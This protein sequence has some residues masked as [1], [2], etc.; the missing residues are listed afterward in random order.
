[1]K[2]KRLGT[3][4]LT[5]II[6][7]T[8]LAGCGAMP[9]TGNGNET[10]ENASVIAATEEDTDGQITLRVVDWSDGS[11]TQRE[12]FHK[13]FEEA[14]PDIKIE[15]TML[16]V[17]QF[18]NTIVT[19]IKSGEGP[20]LFPIP[21][22]LTLNTAVEEGWFQPINDYVTDEFR[23]K[24][25]PEAFAE[26]VTDIGDEWYTVTEQMPIIQCLFFY[27]KDILNQQVLRRFPQHI[28]SLEKPVKKLQRWGM[29]MFMV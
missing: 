7:A 27:N 18:K 1:M 28:Q 13:K 23:N 2:L 11:A 14:H 6:A 21:V 8:T 29:A 20:D 22:G 17:D 5:A 25:D 26:G 3:L 10:G 24:F 12:E 15:Y 16:T 9:S 4:L 19:M